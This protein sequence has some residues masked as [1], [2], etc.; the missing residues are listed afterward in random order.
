MRLFSLRK[1]RALLIAGLMIVVLTGVGYAGSEPAAEKS[2]H[3]ILVVAFGSSMP[4]G[5]AAITAVVDSVKR[6]YPKTEVRLSYTSRIIMKKLAKESSMII[7]EPSIALAKMAFEG[8]TDVAVLSTHIIP[9]AEYRDLTAVVDGFRLMA[10]KGTKAGFKSLTLSEPLLSNQED[11]ERTADILTKTY[12]A[13]GKAGAVVFVGHGTH[14]FADAAYSALQMAFARKSPNFFVGTV[15]GLPDYEDVLTSLKKRGLKRV[16]LAPA[17]LVAGD[18]AHND[19]AGDEDDSWRV[20]L[21]KEKLAVT[22]KLVG[23]GQNEGI[24][25][26]LL[27]KLGKA[28][29]EHA[30][31]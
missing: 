8:F 5:Q 17:M 22:S 12:A 4:E 25:K 18:H 9:G 27:D 14:H 1:F 3:G 24:R 21:T 13:E 10:D 26:M 7:D 29:G 11:F 31:K 15:E 28:W 23:L 6:A 30:P 20:M 16:T 2:K 19:I